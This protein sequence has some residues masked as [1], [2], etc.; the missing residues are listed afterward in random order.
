MPEARAVIT[1]A[2]VHQQDGEWAESL[3]DALRR[4]GYHVLL[5]ATVREAEGL[6]PLLG[7]A[8][9][10]LIITTVQPRLQDPCELG[11]SHVPCIL[12]SA[13]PRP[14]GWPRRSCGG[15]PRRSRRRPC[16]RP[17][18]TPWDTKAHAT[19]TPVGAAGPPPTRAA[20]TADERGTEVRIR[21]Q[22][23]LLSF[24]KVGLH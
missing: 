15:W 14:T 9:L 22:Y 21:H 17:S 11:V 20:R 4:Q 23:Q 12:L 6:V 7:L 19:P 16:W 3:I 10:D 1:I 13:A 24:T 5:A 18:V 8:S 2:F